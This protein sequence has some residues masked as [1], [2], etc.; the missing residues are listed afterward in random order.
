MRKT[1]TP[2]RVIIYT[3]V[4]TSD[5]AEGGVS[6]AA[7]LAKCESYAFTYGLEVV[8]RVEDAGE[9]AK[10]LQ[11]PGWDRVEEFL[12]AGLADGIVI[13]K[14]DRLTRSTGDLASLL[15][16]H[17]TNGVALHSVDE[18]V[19]TSS[20]AGLLILDILTSVSQWERRAISERTRTALRYKKSRGERL[21]KIPYGYRDVDGL[22]EADEDEQRVIKR[23]KALRKG[24]MSY[25]RIANTLNLDSVPA[26]GKCWHK[27]TIVRLLKRE[28]VITRS[29]S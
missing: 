10:S 26:R 8:D 20:A 9:S 23:I 28:P 25:A 16:D 13:A 12:A 22:L 4:S 14:L 3:R 2:Q 15:S 29:K 11:R 24:G 1:A 19:D 7:Q 17:F 6:L 27:T 21:G 18:H 5:Q